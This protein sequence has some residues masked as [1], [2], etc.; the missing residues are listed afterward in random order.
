M[1]WAP[2]PAENA[3]SSY[4]FTSNAP[5]YN[6][7]KTWLVDSTNTPGDGCNIRSLTIGFRHTDAIDFNQL[8]AR[9]GDYALGSYFHTSIVMP[10]CPLTGA[11]FTKLIATLSNTTTI[12]KVVVATLNS[13]L[14][15]RVSRVT[16]LTAKPILHH[17][18]GTL[19]TLNGGPLT[20]QY[21]T[22]W[23]KVA[24]VLVQV[25]DTPHVPILHDF[26]L[27]MRPEGD[28][29][30]RCKF[31]AY[32]PHGAG[33]TP[34][35][36]TPEDVENAVLLARRSQA[37]APAGINGGTFTVQ[38]NQDEWHN[39]MHIHLFLTSP[40]CENEQRYTGATVEGA[41]FTFHSP[42]PQTFAA[43]ATAQAPETK[44]VA[45]IH[46]IGGH[47]EQL[48]GVSVGVVSVDAD[49]LVR[50]Q[51]APMPSYSVPRFDSGILAGPLNFD[52]LQGDAVVDATIQ[53]T[54]FG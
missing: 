45:Y 38:T 28:P 22:R 34:A 48:G 26:E 19:H 36:A 3:S 15:P 43:F 41:W 42:P 27:T 21:G 12:S 2:E 11:H 17:H 40:E 51:S 46:A 31:H 53:E 32:A 35:V 30:R 37:L 23:V 24:I 9:H 8:V 5:Y 20:A 18:T 50:N 52:M 7:A 49:G 54:A 10:P 33:A 13:A 4:L 25:T 29:T 14:L 39:L 44:L 6:S 16:L 47:P 1:V